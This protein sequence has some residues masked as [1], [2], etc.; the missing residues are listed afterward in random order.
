MKIKDIN[1]AINV[2]SHPQDGDESDINM[3]LD[4]AI[5]V[6]KAYRDGLTESENIMTNKQIN[7]I[8]KEY[9]V[10]DEYGYTD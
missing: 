7:K 6:L 5:K 3:A 2:L 1:F 10:M 9:F 8:K 4:I